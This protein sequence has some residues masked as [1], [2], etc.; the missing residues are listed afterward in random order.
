MLKEKPL[1]RVQSLNDFL[2]PA[3]IKSGNEERFLEG[4]CGIHPDAPSV[5]KRALTFLGIEKLVTHHIINSSDN[6][7]ILMDKG[8]GSTE[9]RKAAGKIIGSVQR[10]YYPGIFGIGCGVFIF[11]SEEIM[12]G[13]MLLYQRNNRLFGFDIRAGD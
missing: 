6:Y 1:Y 13:E 10:V 3:V 12:V 9:Y 4:I 7:L 5:K 11:F 2:A 8:N